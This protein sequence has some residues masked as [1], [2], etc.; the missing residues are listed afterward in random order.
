MKILIGN[1]VGNS[2]QKCY[3]NNEYV[4]QPSCYARISKMPNQ[5][6][7]SPE[8]VLKNLYNEIMITINSPSCQTGTYYI[9]KRALSSGLAV[10]NMDVT[11]RKNTS[12]IY[13][14]NTLAMISAYAVSKTENVLQIEDTIK[15]NVDM[16][17]NYLLEVPA[18]TNTNRSE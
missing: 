4:K 1:D 13:Y 17:L 16:A 12:E 15:V 9:G 14:I 8:A 3:I 5:D 6:E 10:Y 18:I 7:V 2:D 11:E